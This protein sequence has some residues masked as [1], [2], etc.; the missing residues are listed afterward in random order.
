M[1]FF[2]RHLGSATTVFFAQI[3]ELISFIT[4]DAVLSCGSVVCM[5]RR[6]YGNWCRSLI[7]GC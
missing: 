6:C 5:V 1:P 2:S 7:M 3:V 4:Y